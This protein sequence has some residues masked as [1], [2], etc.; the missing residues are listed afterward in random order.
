[1][2]AALLAAA[3]L[4]PPQD[5]PCPPDV[6]LD[7]D[8]DR[9]SPAL[10]EPAGPGLWIAGTAFA[11]EDIASATALESELTGN[12]ELNIVFSPAATERFAVI[13]QCRINRIVEVSIDRVVISR[14]VVMEQI[15]GG[16]AR[17]SGD[18]TRASATATAARLAPPKP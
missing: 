3:L 13:T 14:P 7:A 6:E 2:I 11:A 10:V 1:M 17:I 4:A 8:F 9:D 12:W 16:Q 15:R 5:A 18:F